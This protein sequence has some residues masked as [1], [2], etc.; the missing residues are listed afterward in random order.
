MEKEH[1]PNAY[2]QGASSI[3]DHFY[4]LPEDVQERVNA[5]AERRHFRSEKELRQYVEDL[6]RRA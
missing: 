4:F 2:L 3:D 5:R 1:N 6:L